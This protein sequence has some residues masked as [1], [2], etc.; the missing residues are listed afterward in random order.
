MLDYESKEFA[1]PYFNRGAP[2][3]EVEEGTY[4]D[5]NASIAVKEFFW[6]HSL[7]EV[8]QSLL[9]QGLTL[10][11]FKE[12][13]YSVWNCFPGLEEIEEGRF[14]VPS[15]KDFHPPMMFALRMISAT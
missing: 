2:F 15:L 11:H 3:E 14:A 1:Y 7:D 5:P 4:A 6:M 10:T 8:I 13:P 12:F 9:D